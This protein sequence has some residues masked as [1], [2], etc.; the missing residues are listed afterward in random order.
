MLLIFYLLLQEDGV[1][2]ELLRVAQRG[3]R[4]LHLADRFQSIFRVRVRPGELRVEAADVG[5]AA[6]DRRGKRLANVLG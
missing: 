1:L 6:L 5:A 3:R 2:E 4:A